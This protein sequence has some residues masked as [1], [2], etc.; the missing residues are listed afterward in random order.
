MANAGLIDSNRE[1]VHSFTMGTHSLG[2]RPLVQHSTTR[3]ER[4]L[5]VAL[6]ALLPLQDNFPTILG[7]SSSWV[8]F[9]ITAGYIVL[10][11]P[12]VLART[13]THPVFLAS[14][15][16]IFVGILIES[17]HRGI[18]F[19]NPTSSYGE[20]LRIGQMVAGA[21]LVGALCRDRQALR[22]GIYGYV[23]AALWLSVLLM[24]I[25]YGSLRASTANNFA[26]ATQVRATTFAHMPIEANLNTMS[27][28]SAQGFVVALVL[29]LKSNDRY[30]RIL[31]LGAGL[32]CLVAASL[33][34][35]RGGIVV[36]ILTGG[37]ILFKHRGK[38]LRFILAACLIGGVIFL[39]FPHVVFTRLSFSTAASQGRVE[40]RARVYTAAIDHFSE[41]SSWGVGSGN[42]WQ[43]WGYD[44]GF[45]NGTITLG[46][47]NCFFQVTI[48][49]GLLGLAALIGVVWTAYLCLPKW[50][51]RD[52][53]A[54][55][56]FGIA[57][58]LFLWTF[59]VHTLYAKEFSIG[60]GLL[61]GARRWVWR[62][63]LP[64]NSY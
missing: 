60:L 19:G 1:S 63:V 52:E 46:A 26:E 43:T 13:Y 17:T 32:F 9:A 16:L 47:H 4:V 44:H 14:S 55:C 34:L 48:Y 15:A 45:N 6:L 33:P 39:W 7:V 29:F 10:Y 37:A 30:K 24:F 54:L 3:M 12:A 42:F 56:L 51:M 23:I 35:S 20:I 38:H 31:F 36:A 62:S 5:L 41:Y 11:R 50:Y 25:Y 28:F 53:L 2:R 21:V 22:A 59:F 61:V 40:G 64:N 49:W 27:F 57:I 58:S 8:L 18:S